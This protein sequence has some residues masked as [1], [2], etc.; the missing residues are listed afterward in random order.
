MNM[1][2]QNADTSPADSNTYGFMINSLLLG[3]A[4]VVPFGII[5]LLNWLKSIGY[6]VQ[7]LLVAG[8]SL[9]GAIGLMVVSQAEIRNIKKRF[10]HYSYYKQMIITVTFTFL[11]IIAAMLFMFLG[12]GYI[13]TTSLMN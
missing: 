11:G 5:I 10:H 1:D 8:M 9:A 12:L 7:P 6:F 2:H 13:V 4:A 3:I